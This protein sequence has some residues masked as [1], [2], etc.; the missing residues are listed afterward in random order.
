M[1]WVRLNLLLSED[2]LCAEL[3]PVA[4]SEAVVPTSRYRY[5]ERE[6]ERER[7]K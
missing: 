2:K 3:V 7:E 5:R 4:V 6:R 1:I